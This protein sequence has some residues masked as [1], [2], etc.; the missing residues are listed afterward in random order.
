MSENPPPFPPAWAILPRAATRG[1]AAAIQNISKPRRASSEIKRLGIGG[2]G[3]AEGLAAS[4]MAAFCWQGA[5]RS[6]QKLDQHRKVV[7]F[8][9]Q[10]EASPRLWTDQGRPDIMAP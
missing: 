8:A 10:L 5:R 9:A 6:T 4:L 3:E 2:S 7:L 1:S